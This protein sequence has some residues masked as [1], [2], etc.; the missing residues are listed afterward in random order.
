[1]ETH[2]ARMQKTNNNQENLI[3]QRE[4]VHYLQP[5]QKDE[6]IRTNENANVSTIPITYNART[7]KQEPYAAEI[8]ES[9]QPKPTGQFH[10]PDE[11][12]WSAQEQ[13]EK[14]GQSRKAPKYNIRNINAG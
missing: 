6:R 8:I 1:M 12:R 3:K 10:D 13:K 7:A 9:A 14:N 11:K 4:M 2:E 5:T